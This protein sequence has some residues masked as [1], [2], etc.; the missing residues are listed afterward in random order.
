MLKIA[1]KLLRLESGTGKILEFLLFQ[2]PGDTVFAHRAGDRTAA[3]ER[4]AV[5]FRLAEICRDNR[6]FADM[7]KMLALYLRDGRDEFLRF[8]ALCLTGDLS[9][10]YALAPAL[11]RNTP[12]PEM[13]MAAA[14]PWENIYPL[15]RIKPAL[16]GVEAALPGLKGPAKSLAGLHRFILAQKAGL[17][18]GFDL[19]RS[20]SA[21]SA[22]LLLPAAKVFLE[23]LEFEKAEKILR[24]AEQAWPG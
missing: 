20:I 13:L 2:L 19:P 24:A 5:F 10:A 11:I 7:D 3:L 1:F 23:R 12:S 4:A 18:P 8:L 22:I 15:R 17:N 9:K 21:A 14:D 6:S 16:A